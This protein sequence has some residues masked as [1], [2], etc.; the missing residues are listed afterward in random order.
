MLVQPLKYFGG[1]RC[2]WRQVRASWIMAAIIAIPQL[3]IF[4]QTEERRSSPDATRDLII[5]RCESAGYSAQWQRKVY[6]TFM[7]SY[8]LLIPTGIMGYC[9]ASIIRVVWLRAEV[10]PAP[11]IDV[12]PVH[13]AS[14]CR[15]DHTVQA[16]SNPTVIVSTA[17]QQRPDVP[18]CRSMPVTSHPAIGV[19]RRMAVMTKRSVIKMSVSVTVAFVA[20]WTPYFVISLIRIYSDYQYTLTTSLAV[21]ELLA[22]SHSTLNPFL[23]I[24]FST[25]AVR[26]AFLQ[27][28]R[29]IVPRCCQLRRRGLG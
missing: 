14:R 18:R 9:Y 13:L 4:V 22:L 20:C 27:L 8:M 23:Y 5:Y 2:V 26:D 11:D 3:F 28:C 15:S 7:T 10:Q 12:P 21:S 19:P 17:H 25:R 16:A 6:L 1:T 29:R 24:I